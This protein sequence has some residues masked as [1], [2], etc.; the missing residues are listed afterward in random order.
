MNYD[1]VRCNLINVTLLFPAN[2]QCLEI[3]KTLLNGRLF[4]HY[5]VV[6]SIVMKLISLEFLKFDQLQNSGRCGFK[7]TEEDCKDSTALLSS[8]YRAS[9]CLLC[10]DK[11]D[12][13][14]LAPCRV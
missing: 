14:A 1:T 5:A 10:A 3:F 12:K 8:K 2:E 11:A 7:R 6:D 9:W 13:L 4:D